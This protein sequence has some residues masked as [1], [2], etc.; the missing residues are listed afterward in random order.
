MFLFIAKLLIKKCSFSFYLHIHE[1][2]NQSY[3][4]KGDGVTGDGLI[5]V[6]LHRR[7]FDVIYMGVGVTTMSQSLPF[8][9]KL[10]QL[11]TRHPVTFYRVRLIIFIKI[12]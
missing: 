7:V 5:W 2:M 3:S 1:M 10:K 6:R 9:F 8:Q 12:M 4:V 11:V